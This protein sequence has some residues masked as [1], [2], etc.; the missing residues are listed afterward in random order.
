[1]TSNLL[2]TC[3]VLF[4]LP[5]APIFSQNALLIRSVPVSKHFDSGDY[6]GGTQSWSFDQ[7]STGILYAANNSGLL[8]FDGNNWNNYNTSDSGLPSNYLY[9]VTLDDAGAKGGFANAR[10]PCNEEQAWG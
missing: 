5:L 8:E 3:F 10:L 6:P 7:S 2:K 4:L 9:A 1:M